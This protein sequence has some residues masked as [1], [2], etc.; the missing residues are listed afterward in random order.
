MLR[1]FT[2]IKNFA[3]AATDGEIGKVKELYFDD[4][5]WTVRYV[6]VDTGGW[7]TGRKVLLAPRSFGMIDQEAKRITVHL[8]REQIENSP[9][10]DADKPVSRQHEEEWHRYYGYPGYWMMPEAI[11]FGVAP[12]AETVSAAREAKNEEHGDPHLRST[13][14]VTGYSIHATD[15]DIG[16]VD[17]FIVD[18]GDWAIRYVVISRSWWPGKK[19]MLSSEWIERVSWDARQIFVPLSRETIKGAPDWDDTQPLSRA[20]E[21]RLFDYYEMR[22]YW[23]IGV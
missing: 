9:S 6:V 10:I 20:D 19:V 4:K 23:P 8:T 17:D 22:G 14:E 3:L 13:S 2:D 7:L 11:A 15:G 16:H 21:Q 5:N 18:D 12:L 1:P